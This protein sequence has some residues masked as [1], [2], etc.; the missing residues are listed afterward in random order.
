MKQQLVFILLNFLFHI[1]SCQPPAG[2]SLNKSASTSRKLNQ[3]LLCGAE[4][5]EEYLPILKNKSVALVVNQTARVHQTHL[6]D[7]LLT[8]GINIRRIFAPEH[9]FRGG[10]DAGEHV[11]DSVDTKTGIPVVSLYGSKKKPGAEDLKDIDIVVFDIQDVGARFYTFIS[12]LH[13]LMEASA[14]HGKELLVLDR[15]NPNGWYVDGPVLRPEF[16]SFVGVAPIPVV[17]G[18]TVGEYAGM[19]NG[20]HWIAKPCSLRVISCWN[21]DHKIRYS[22]PVKPSPNLP[23]DVAIRLYPYLCFFE[24][25]NVSVGR[26]TDAPF[27]V[28][29]SPETKF[30]GAYIF[31]PQSKP[32]A[33][34]PPFLNQRCYGY[35]LRNE[36]ETEGRYLFYYVTKMYRHYSNKKDFF[37]KN[38]FFDNLC[39]TDRIR[40]MMEEGRSDEEIR[41]SY[42]EE[43]A[44]YK[45]IRKKYLLYPDFE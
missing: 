17:H 39:G 1:S 36:Q 8:K 4:R 14:E 13:Y 7:T 34:N 33:K 41:E 32:G 31:T 45:I 3:S 40:R 21:Y 38:R 43:L 29:G 10:A 35:D 19:V 24:G 23:N 30:E 37:L 25:A 22:L 16:Q 6:V 27:Q 9:G 15:P 11:R 5:M 20:E 18:L 44:A 2:Q 28:M 26:G 42:K 12:T